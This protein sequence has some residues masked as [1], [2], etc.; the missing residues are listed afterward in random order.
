MEKAIFITVDNNKDLYEKCILN[1]K[2][3]DNNQY[4]ELVRF[5][6]TV[7]NIFIPVRYNEFLNNYDYSQ[8]AWFVFL[9][10]D[11]EM[12]ENIIPKLQNLD[13]TKMYSPFG[14][15]L[16]KKSEN[17]FIKETIGDI[18]DCTRDGKNPRHLTM[19][20]D[21]G[22]KVDLPDC[23]CFIVHSSLV[24]KYNLRFDEKCK[25]DLYVEDFSINANIK[26][27][28]DT[29][30]LKLKCNHWS[31]LKD[32]Q[33]RPNYFPVLDYVL[34]K[35][36]DYKDK[37]IFYLWGT[38]EYSYNWLL[39]DGYDGEDVCYRYDIPVDITKSYDVRVLIYDQIQEESCVLDVGCSCGALGKVLKEN[40]KCDVYGFE[41][42]I[43]AIKKAKMLNVYNQ[44]H[45]V[46]LNTF[47]PEE[48]SDYYGKFDYIVLADV[49]EHLMN[50]YES[51]QKLKQFLKTDGYFLM[52]IPNIA[53]SSI[54][55]ALLMDRWEYADTGLLDRTHIK[56]FTA[57]TIQET[58]SKCG[59]SIDKLDFT[60]YD[61]LIDNICLK[62][63]FKI[64][65]FVFKSPQSFVFQYFIKCKVDISRK[66][67]NE[68]LLYN[69]NKF[70]DE[71]NH[72]NDKLKQNN[73]STT[74]FL[75]RT[76]NNYYSLFKFL[77]YKYVLKNK[78]KEIKYKQK[79]ETR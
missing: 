41:Y 19:M 37:E 58:L 21:G 6:N 42:D 35:Y 49:L 23:M 46:D 59:L 11:F 5:D 78:N 56:F 25:F 30:F 15:N 44:I 66:T 40:K 71:E 14:F 3:I 27:N 31:Q 50:P 63:P 17:E 70:V 54:K 20:N 74:S 26:H 45:Q 76:N 55:T 9:H 62:L 28:I 38:S 2:F 12:L 33:E 18:Y 43:V 10:N 53:H 36:K 52:S 73:V 72:I 57:K 4:I 16:F 64:K 65:Q 67:Y 7:E 32:I 8:D 69:K 1:N 77:F 34:D 24:A 48:Y 51:L 29:V 60:I 79:L 61:N 75:V 13:K 68:I 47:E 22:R 39:P